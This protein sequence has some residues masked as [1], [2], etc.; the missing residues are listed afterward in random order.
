MNIFKHKKEIILTVLTLIIF[1]NTWAYVVSLYEENLKINEYKV[2]EHEFS[3]SVSSLELSLNQTTTFI[4]GLRGFVYSQLANGINE[5][6]FNQYADKTQESAYSIKNFSIAPGNIQTFVY[7]LKGNEVTIGHDLNKDER[8]NIQADLKK[9][10]STKT[11]VMSGPYELRQGGLGLI[12]RDPIFSNGEYWGIANIVVDVDDVIAR[13]NMVKEYSGLEFTIRTENENMFYGEKQSRKSDFTT[14]IIVINQ[15]W[16]IDAYIIGDAGTSAGYDT[17]VEYF[18]IISFFVLLFTITLIVSNIYRNILLSDKVKDMIY[19]DAL[20]G[21]PNRRALKEKMSEAIKTNHKF[22]VTFLDLDNF[23]NIN[24][25]LGHSIGDQVLITIS[26]RLSSFKNENVSIF[27]W[28]GDEFLI[29]TEDYGLEEYI[30]PEFLD[31]IEQIREPIRLFDKDYKLSASAGISFYPAD[32]KVVEELLKNSDIAMYHAKKSGKDMVRFYNEN[33][34]KDTADRIELEQKLNYA[35][36]EKELEVYFQPK[37]NMTTNEIIGAEALVRWFSDGVM[38]SPDKFIAVAETNGLITKIDQ[39]VLRETI[40][41]IKH[42]NSK[43]VKLQVSCNISAQ[44]FNEQI[45]S[46]IKECFEDSDIE[47]GQLE[48]EI[49]ETTAIENFE[50]AKELINRLKNI[51]VGVALDDFGTGYSSLS[52]LSKLRISTIKIDR[53]FIMKLED[54]SYENKIVKAIISLASDINMKIIAEGVETKE[55]KDILRS[56]DCDI[57]QGFY[58]SKAIPSEDFENFYKKYNSE[59][60]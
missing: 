9:V 36:E 8:T 1:F 23:K 57:C 29:I 31:V 32:G 7:P 52:Y 39:F 18:K 35:L 21:L 26:K 3:D 16:T 55:Q 53:S 27:R 47:S 54:N 28:G 2:L 10:I 22:A 34:G 24:D 40:K 11:T 14:E 59:N 41:F 42:W 12:V 58:Y 60:S 4:Y 43:G 49:T 30:L 5:I 19:K 25:V 13:S 15:V 33:I 56:L 51:G 45:I 50:Y 44:Q 6:S 37:M 46:I 20:T 38:I 48:L 17:R